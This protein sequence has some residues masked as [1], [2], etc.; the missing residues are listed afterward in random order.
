MVSISDFGV[1]YLNQS[2]PF[3]GAK[4]SGYGRF[5]GPEGLRSLCN[6]KAI[7]EDRFHNWV[8]TSIPPPLTYPITNPKTAWAFIDGMI[9]LMFAPSWLAKVAGLWALATS[10]K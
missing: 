4:S 7:T 1:F 3:G 10:R 8:Q 2:L 6:L 5:S 9:D